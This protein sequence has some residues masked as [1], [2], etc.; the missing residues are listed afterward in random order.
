MKMTDLV[1]YLK[2]IVGTDFKSKASVPAGK[3]RTAYLGTVGIT[4]GIAQ[5]TGDTSR[6]TPPMPK[7]K[8]IPGHIQGV[9][10]REDLGSPVKVQIAK[11]LTRKEALKAAPWKK[12]YGDVRGFSYNAKTGEACW[13]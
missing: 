9:K 2:P 12:S 4:M 6:A 3:S 1:P 11:G 7:Y 13:I 10:F 5:P 8:T